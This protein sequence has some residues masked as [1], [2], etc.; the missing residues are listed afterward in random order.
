MQA[1]ARCRGR[2]DSP[3]AAV[4]PSEMCTRSLPARV[5]GLWILRGTGGRYPVRRCS[6]PPGRRAGHPLYGFPGTAGSCKRR[7]AALPHATATGRRTT[8][9]PAQ[10]DLPRPRPPAPTTTHTIH[11]H[12]PTRDRQGAAEGKSAPWLVPNRVVT[13]TDTGPNHQPMQ[14]MSQQM[15]QPMPQQK[16]QRMLPRP[17]A[18]V[19]PRM[20]TPAAVALY[21]S[22]TAGTSSR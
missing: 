3:S 1:A 13:C 19:A 21:V 8:H 18:Y 20:T 22:A 12:T 2:G 11:P 9:Q 17:R 10:P 7:H 15:L 6:P 5:W 16:M 4:P 14:Q